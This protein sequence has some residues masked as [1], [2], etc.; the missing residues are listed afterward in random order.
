MVLCLLAQ[1][2]LKSSKRSGR[3][4]NQANATSATPTTPLTTLTTDTANMTAQD[5]V[6]RAGNA[7]LR[8]IDPSDPRSPLQLN[9][10]IDWN[11]DTGAT[12]HMTPHR[13]WLR[14][15][16]PK[17]VPIKLADN[18]VIYSAG[19]GSVVF[20]PNLE[21]K[22]GRAVEF[23][24]VLHV[25]HLRNTLLAVLYLTRRSS[26]VVNINAS[27]M[28]FARSAGPPPLFVAPINDHNA[29]FL[30][31]VTEPTTEFANPATTIPLELSLS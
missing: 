8:S 22:R 16:T 27:H 14:T 24:N 10:D 7:R 23:S 19:V 1:N 4:P 13:H 12:S 15:Y 18:T 11:A 3:R 2:N 25:P 6:E 30:D 31:G 9:A 28:S 20:H 21:G 29:A 5:V 17:R 26:F